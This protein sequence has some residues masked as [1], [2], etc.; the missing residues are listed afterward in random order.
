MMYNKINSHLDII[1]CVLLFFFISGCKYF[2][3]Q[4]LLSN[5]IDTILNYTQDS[6]F[7]ANYI[8]KEEMKRIEEEAKAKIDSIKK[9][10]SEKYTGINDVYHIVVGSFKIEKNAVN[11]MQCIANQGY[12]P[13]ILHLNNGFHL[14]VASSFNTY[15]DAKKALTALQKHVTENAWMYIK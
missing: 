8:S 2:E 10:Y 15:S 4:S 7:K 14:V 12:K 1:F 5:D 11:Y 13:H 3:K 6:V 9:A